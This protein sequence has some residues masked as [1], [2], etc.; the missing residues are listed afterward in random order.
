MGSGRRILHQGAVAQDDAKQHN[1]DV[2]N[3]REYYGGTHIHYH[4]SG[5]TSSEASSTPAAAQ[6]Q[7]NH[8]GSPFYALQSAVE[9]VHYIEC[10]LQAVAIAIDVCRGSKSS[11]DRIEEL[12]DAR[13][14]IR[15]SH[16]DL[17]EIGGQQNTRD[18]RDLTKSAAFGY[19]AAGSLA[20]TLENLC[21]QISNEARGDELVK[22]HS[23]SHGLEKQ[24]KQ[25]ERSLQDILI[26]VRGIIR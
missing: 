26:T 16:V 12:E 23:S 7:S 20:T 4:G 3:E 13:S 24:Q 18:V 25:L 2:H 8:T 17:G 11:G 14:K 10:N 15:Q 19:K 1:G 22:L 9:I 21:R 5:A 6:A